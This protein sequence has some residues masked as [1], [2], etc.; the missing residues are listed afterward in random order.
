MIAIIGVSILVVIIGSIGLYS[1]MAPHTALPLTID[2]IQ[3]NAFEQLLFHIH[4]HLDIV[5]NGQYFLVPAQ[6]GILLDAFIGYIRM[7]NQV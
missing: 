7:T 1:A 2:G 5:I 6:T 3:C 4:A